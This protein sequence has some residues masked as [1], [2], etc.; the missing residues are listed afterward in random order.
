[1]L[2]SKPSEHPGKEVQ[3][4]TVDY[5]PGSVDPVHRHEQ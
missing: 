4:I 1:M 3:M 2:R 5:P